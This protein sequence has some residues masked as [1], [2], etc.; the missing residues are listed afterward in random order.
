MLY[1]AAQ[2]A[3]EPPDV[4]VV[5]YDTLDKGSSPIPWYLRATALCRWHRSRVYNAMLNEQQR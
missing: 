1:A 4:M 5:P 2:E 3:P